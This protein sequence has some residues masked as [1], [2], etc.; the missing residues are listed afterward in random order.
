MKGLYGC[1]Q[2]LLTRVSA[3]RISTKIIRVGHVR[4]QSNV[5]FF[6]SNGKFQ[7]ILSPTEKHYNFS[8][9]KDSRKVPADYSHNIEVDATDDV[10]FVLS[11]P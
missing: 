2:W 8:M 11:C 7:P 5:I 4:G 10:Y 3:T 6:A 1:S 9:V